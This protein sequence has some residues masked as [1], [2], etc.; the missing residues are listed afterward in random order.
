MGAGEIEESSRRV[1]E[2]VIKSKEFRSANVIGAYFATRS[3]VRTNLIVAQAKKL[4]KKVM[5]P[6]TEGDTIKFYEMTD[7]L[8]VGRFGIMEP[9]PLS[10]AGEMD[11]V[12]V[13]GVA[14]DRR[15]YR[16]GYGKGYYD[17]FLSGSKAF[18]LGLS[19]DLQVVDILPH[20]AHDQKLDALATESGIIY[21]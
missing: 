21:F 6:R 18:S 10:P 16:V 3:E 1:Q 4:K 14:F 11:L 9:L 5:L 20:G 2:S 12:I 8:A 13:P 19:Y 17:R 7:K 15:G